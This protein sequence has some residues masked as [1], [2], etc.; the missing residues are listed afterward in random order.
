MM[1]IEGCARKK[2]LTPPLMNIEMNPSANSDAEL[3]R[4][5]EPYRLPSQ[6]ST[7]IVDGIVI[8]SVGKENASDEIGI[9]SADEHVVPVDHVA[10][11]GQRAHGINQHAVAEHRLAHVGDQNVRNDAHA[12][13]DGDV[14]LGMSEE[15]EQVLPQQSRSAGV[16]Q[17][18]VI[19]DRVRRHEETGSGDVIENQQNAGGHQHRKRR[20][21]HA[22]R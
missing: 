16:R 9:H 5:L 14:D 8:T 7:T 13:H 6:I 17:D 12:G 19:D 15:P 11:N 20:Q 18:L 22:P 2:P 21:A 10:E 4:N 3:I 1:S